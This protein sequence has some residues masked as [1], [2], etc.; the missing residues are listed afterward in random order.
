MRILGLD[1]G[2]KRIGIAMSDPSETIA[3][4]LDVLQSRGTD[5]NIR[6]IG[7]LVREHDVGK[8]VVGLAISLDG[9]I[10]SQ[11]R[12]AQAFAERLAEALNVPVELSDERLSSVAAERAMVEGGAKRAKRREKRDAVAA[13]IILQGYLD[14][15][16]REI[17]S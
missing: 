7:R 13:A 1:P 9:G 4:P 10:S 8:V 2:E 15:A 12:R 5:A 11:A 17:S 6:S 14:R 3:S 16:K